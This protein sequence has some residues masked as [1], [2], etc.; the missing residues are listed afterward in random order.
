MSKL[1]SLVKKVA[2]LDPVTHRKISCMVGAAVG[3]ACCVRLEWIY[4]Q[5][6]L[7]RIVGKEDPVFWK[8]SHSPYYILPNGKISGYGDQAIQTLQSMA[9]ND[10][11]FD[12]KKLLDHYCNYFGDPKSSYQ[13]ALEKRGNWKLST[14]A[15][16]VEGLWIQKA[17]IKMMENYKNGIWPTG[18]K[19][20]YEHD[21][22]VAFIPLIIQQ[23]PDL[24][25]EKLQNAIK[26]STQF[27]FSIG[28]HIVEAELLSEFIKGSGENSVKIVKEKF[29]DTM[30]CQ[31]ISAVERGL[32]EGT[33]PKTLVRKCGMAC[34]LPGSFMSSL[35]SIIRAQNYAEGI[36]E[37]IRCAGALCARSNFIGA[38]LG[39]KYGIQNIPFE[40]IERIEGM[41]TIIENSLKCFAK[42]S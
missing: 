40:W 9:D 4:S 12:E 7:E 37:T 33:D 31:E 21:G 22:L 16:P 6:Q 11:V 39:A 17:V 8:D 42:E 26:L 20:A 27:P 28:H 34:E 23:S 1:A 41:E 10:G 3:D 24:D 14:A 13:I 38:C 15:L 18:A 19:D 29:P 2:E 5:N 36:R 32:A 25:Y 35:V 30:V